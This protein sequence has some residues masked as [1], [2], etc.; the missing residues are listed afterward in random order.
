MY[1]LFLSLAIVLTAN[2]VFTQNATDR[3]YY[4]KAEGRPRSAC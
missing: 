2:T 4:S 1:K 3:T